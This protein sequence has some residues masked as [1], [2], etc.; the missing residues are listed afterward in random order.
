MKKI[1]SGL[2]ILMLPVL[3]FANTCESV[4]D[5]ST[6]NTRV[7]TCDKEKR[8]TTTFKTTNDVEVLKNSV[9]TIKC[10][11]ELAISVDP[12]VKVLAGMGFNYPLYVS[13]ERK[14]TA[15]YNYDS[16]ETK[17]KK[18]VEEYAKLTGTEKTTKGNEITNYNEE[19]KACDNF[20]DK[21]AKEYNK[22]ELN[23]NVSIKI[24]TDKET[25]EEV[26]VYKNLQEETY[27]QEA[28]IDDLEYDACGFLESSKT[29]RKD[30]R[31]L[32][33]WTKTERV[34][35]KYT[36][37]DVYLEKYTGEVKTL[38]ISGRTCDAKDMYFTD[39]NTITKPV[40]GVPGDKGYELTLT[41]TNLGSLLKSNLTVNCNYE[42]KN[43]MY[44]QR[45]NTGKCIDE[46]CD[47]YG[48]TGYQY[49]IIDLSDPFPN[50]KAG[51]N[52]IGKE[53]LITS[54]KDNINSMTKFEINLGRSSI[55]KLREYNETHKY[56]KFDL[57]EKTNEL[58]F[59][60]QHSNIVK[61]K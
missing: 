61:R 42:V 15:K 10:S 16:Y 30:E 41:A 59:I 44:P 50:R 1:V 57:D 29:C 23:S 27:E 58:N 11:E 40:S 7:L 37:K 33:G 54:T 3:V 39:F 5:N 36:F 47:K 51:A 55:L 4:K 53:N 26:Y 22:Y 12:V 56:D 43:L 24:H 18:L 31:T 25:K 46:N 35:G 8:T 48:S 2:V 52:W 13:G 32:V 20:K 38:P 17:I 19:K 6:G 45:D 21:E 14:C 28:I 9:C 49:R 60:E 34:Y